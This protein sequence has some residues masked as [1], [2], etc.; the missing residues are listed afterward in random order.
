MY[1]VNVQTYISYASV[2]ISI[3]RAFAAAHST[4]NDARLN[5]R[6]TNSLPVQWN[7]S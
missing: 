6:T 5:E 1:N 2:V 4:P 7:T 3:G